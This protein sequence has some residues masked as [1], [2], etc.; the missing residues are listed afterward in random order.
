MTVVW[1]L[2][3]SRL[4]NEIF[5]QRTCGRDWRNIKLSC[6]YREPLSASR[7]AIAAQKVLTGTSRDGLSGG[8][9][10]FSVYSR[11]NHLVFCAQSASNIIRMRFYTRKC[12]PP[13]TFCPCP[14]S[15][16]SAGVL[17]RRMCTSHMCV[18]TRAHGL[19]HVS[20]DHWRAPA[21]RGAR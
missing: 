17:W 13:G 6:V 20:T 14:F 9:C 2:S 5:Y 8:N 12:W 4:L 7:L 18:R 21:G 11:D 15:A 1:C 10:Q 19:Q 3:R 16:V